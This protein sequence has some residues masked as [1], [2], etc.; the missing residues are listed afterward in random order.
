MLLT[1][2]NF[3]TSFYDPAG[4]GD[5]ILYQHLFSNEIFIKYYL[6][7]FFVIIIVILLNFNFLIFIKKFFGSLISPSFLFSL[8]PRDVVFDYQSK[9]EEGLVLKGLS[10]LN[11]SSLIL[12][13]DFDFN[14]FY[15]KYKAYLPNK[16]IPS[17][18]FLI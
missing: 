2:R 9:R 6:Y 18:N 10:R 11:Y 15:D 7:L 16:N 13:N 4:G 14:L 8:S 1:D 17:N 5:P 12:N 3:N